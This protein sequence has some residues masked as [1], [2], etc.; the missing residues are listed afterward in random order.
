ML[1]PFMLEWCTRMSFYQNAAITECTHAN[2]LQSDLKVPGNV[3]VGAVRCYK[4]ALRYAHFQAVHQ[5]AQHIA[6]WS[7]RMHAAQNLRIEQRS[8]TYFHSLG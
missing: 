2:R 8:V 5:V 6:L 3:N 4:I 7:R 1:E